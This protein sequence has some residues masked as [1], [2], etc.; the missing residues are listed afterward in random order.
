MHTERCGN[1]N[2]Q[3]AA[4]MEAKIKIIQDFTY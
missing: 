1:G 4:Q 2:G 3:G